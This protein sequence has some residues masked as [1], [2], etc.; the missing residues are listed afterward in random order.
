PVFEPVVT[1]NR[2][3][4]HSSRLPQVARAAWPAALLLVFAAVFRGAGEGAAS[5]TGGT[6]AASAAQ[7]ADPAR[8]LAR[9]ERFAAAQPD[10]VGVLL[11][12]GEAYESAGRRD[13]AEATY[14]RALRV[15]ARDGDVH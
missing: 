13:D 9:L 1:E 11:D 15:D 12:L 2:P 14:R 6:A 4:R 10:E 5:R 8:D 7:C 3:D